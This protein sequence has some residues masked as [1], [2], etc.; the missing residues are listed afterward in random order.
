[1]K[2]D[3]ERLG[4]RVFQPINA[5]QAEVGRLR[6]QSPTKADFD[7]FMTGMEKAMGLFDEQQKRFFIQGEEI[8]GQGD[9]LDLHER[10]LD[11]HE[12]RIR[13]LETG[14]QNPG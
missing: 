12:G 5:L 14:K 2:D 9:R 11:S 8:G 1:T 4:I 6:E 13:S 3:L 10:R 7:R